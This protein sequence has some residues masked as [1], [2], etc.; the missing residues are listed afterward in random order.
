MMMFAAV[1]SQVAA[2]AVLA[3]LAG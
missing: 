3:M 1:G 2:V